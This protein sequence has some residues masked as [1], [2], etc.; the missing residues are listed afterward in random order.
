LLLKP[1]YP[2]WILA[3]DDSESDI[4]LL[5]RALDEA[6]GSAQVVRAKDG[7]QAVDLI[8]ELA[9]DGADS[10]PDLIVLDLNLPCIDGH[11]V[12]AVLGAKEAFKA[13]PVLVVTSSEEQSDKERA[14]AEGADAYFVKPLTFDSYRRL[15]KAID[16]ARRARSQKTLPSFP[17]H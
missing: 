10:V 2:P 16:D 11:E 12:L 7:E 13:V 4:Y 3:V 8:N 9:K 1:P 15:P 17:P 14:L 5:E 6:G